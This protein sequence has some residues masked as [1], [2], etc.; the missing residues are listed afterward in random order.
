MAVKEDFEI[1]ESEQ[2]RE[3]VK[4]NNRLEEK[5]TKKN[6]KYIFDL[7]KSLKTSNLSEEDKIK[8]LH[9]IL[10]VLVSKQKEGKTARQLF[11]TVSE[12]TEVIINTLVGVK[13]SSSPLLMWLDNTLLLLG[14]SSI[15]VTI[16]GFFSSGITPTY[17][18]TTLVLESTVGGWIF[19]LIYKYIYQYEYP[20][21]DHNKKPGMRQTLLIFGGATLIWILSFSVITLLP[22]VFNPLLDNVIIIIVGT[23]ALAVRYCLKKKY[24]IVGSISVLRR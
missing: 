19:Y 18:I 15:M 6:Q 24:E 3:I 23:I 8:T 2:L 4:E 21:A 20:G 22:S 13:K 12:R 10:P 5:L 7:K 17:G 14:L 1:M 11:G 9:D 16:T